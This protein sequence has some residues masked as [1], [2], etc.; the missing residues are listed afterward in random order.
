[1]INYIFWQALINLYDLRQAVIK[2]N[3]EN[4]ITHLLHQ[5]RAFLSYPDLFYK[6]AEK[7]NYTEEFICSTLYS[8]PA[9]NMPYQSSMAVKKGSQFREIFSVK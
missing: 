7:Q 2:V 3:T 5:T 4:E 1:M 9:G 8:F 6:T